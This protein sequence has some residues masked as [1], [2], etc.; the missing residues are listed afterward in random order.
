[1]INAIYEARKM[2]EKLEEMMFAGYCAYC[3]IKL[4]YLPNRFNTINW[5]H[6]IRVAQGG[7]DTSLNLTPSCKNC[8]SRLNHFDSKWATVLG[9]KEP[10]NTNW[11]NIII[12]EKRDHVNHR[13]AIENFN[14]LLDIKNYY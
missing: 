5:D 11:K 4:T 12:Q 2:A 3:S 8:N 6:L 7:L 10:Y 1:M 14:N 9:M 13:K